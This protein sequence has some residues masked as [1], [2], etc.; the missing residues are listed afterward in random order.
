M[1]NEAEYQTSPNF[2][3]QKNREDNINIETSIHKANTSE[4]LSKTPIARGIKQ[5]NQNI[6]KETSV[7]QAKTNENSSKTPIA[8]G[9]KQSN[10][11]ISKETSIPISRINGTGIANKMP[12]LT[13]IN[14]N[15]RNQNI[16]LTG[17]V[18]TTEM[19]PKTVNQYNSYSLAASNFLTKPKE[20]SNSNT[21]SKDNKLESIHWVSANLESYYKKHD[22][23]FKDNSIVAKARNLNALSATSNY[24][25]YQNV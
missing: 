2:A 25:V 19:K 7:P 21:I 10:Q 9:I 20:M 11:N 5:S 15:N 16:G 4:I 14:T 12:F 23:N 1:K 18:R 3:E 24:A 13:A 6:S 8:R 22:M 17:A